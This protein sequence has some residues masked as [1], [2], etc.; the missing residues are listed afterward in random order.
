MCRPSGEI[1]DRSANIR[2][3]NHEPGLNL[4]FV[5]SQITSRTSFDGPRRRTT[6][7]G[8]SDA[9][10]TLRRGA[11]W[12]RLFLTA[13]SPFSLML[14]VSRQWSKGSGRRA[15]VDMWGYLPLRS[16]EDLD[17]RAF[18]KPRF[19]A[20]NPCRN[21]LSEKRRTCTYIDSQPTSRVRWLSKR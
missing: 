3:L 2:P 14:T 20:E 11:R 8:A 18:G 17:A 6:P 13:T 15:V 21:E 5:R 7:T 1:S 10:R 9:S 12:V 16:G 4:S 19:A